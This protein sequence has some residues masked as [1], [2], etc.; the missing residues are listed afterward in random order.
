MMRMRKFENVK[1]EMGRNVI[2]YKCTGSLL[3]LS[4]VK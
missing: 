2:I 3:G 1:M 4:K